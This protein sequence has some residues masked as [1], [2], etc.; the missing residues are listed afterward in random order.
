MCLFYFILFYSR[1]V[2][3]SCLLR[4]IIC[5]SQIQWPCRCEAVPTQALWRRGGRICGEYGGI[6]EEA[7]GTRHL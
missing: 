5:A 2:Q 3:S 7:I 4:S 6:R 1:Y